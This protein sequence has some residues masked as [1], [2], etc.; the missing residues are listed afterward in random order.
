MFGRRSHSLEETLGVIF[1][2]ILAAMEGWTQG[3]IL[4]VFWSE[5]IEDT[6]LDL[7]KLTVR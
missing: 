5:I 6:L 4:E 1:G 3:V 2:V 7:Q